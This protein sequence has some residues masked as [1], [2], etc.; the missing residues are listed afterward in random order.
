MLI[1]S[2][3]LILL[4]SIKIAQNKT[5]LKKLYLDKILGFDFKFY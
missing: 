3:F 4:N 2:F 5:K 1:Q